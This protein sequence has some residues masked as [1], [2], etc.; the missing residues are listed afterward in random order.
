MRRN[1]F[2]IPLLMVLIGTV[3][4]LAFVVMGA[5]RKPRGYPHQSRTPFNMYYG[6]RLPQTV[7]YD[8]SDVPGAVILPE[9]TCIYDIG[10]NIFRFRRIY[11]QFIDADSGGSINIDSIFFPGDSSGY[12]NARKGIF[13]SLRA[14]YVDSIYPDAPEFLVINSDT[15]KIIGS[16]FTMSDHG[17][18]VASGKNSFAF[19]GGA[20]F[21]PVIVTGD[22]S[23]GWGYQVTVAGEGAGGWGDVNEFNGNYCGGWGSFVTIDSATAG[24]WGD[25]LLV[26][27]ISSGAIGRG[28]TVE[29]PF[30]MAIGVE[31]QIRGDAS[32]SCG[33]VLGTGIVNS[34]PYAI[35]V[36]DETTDILNTPHTF[37]IMLDSTV[38]CQTRFTGGVT[39]PDYLAGDNDWRGQETFSANSNYD[40]LELSGI[41]T[42]SCVQVTPIMRAKDSAP[43]TSIVAYTWTDT[44]VVYLPTLTDTSKIDKWNWV[45]IR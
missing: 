14:L 38:I 43:T 19:G 25:Y 29:T 6:I 39:V 5:K 42:T 12:F 44:I 35:L 20:V 4:F 2:W 45:W 10:S 7:F 11:T 22:Y 37:A 15:V 27:G 41:T 21:T 32:D 30:S 13:D 28:D 26:R 24:G 18:N 36:G 3:S 16:H 1:K 34:V 31:C 23:G 17:A 33:I 8:S 40:T 9:S